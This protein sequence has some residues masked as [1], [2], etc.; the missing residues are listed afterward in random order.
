MKIAFKFFLVFIVVSCGKVYKEKKEVNN[1]ENKLGFEMT[2]HL[3]ELL[4]E[5]E[6][7]LDN[8]YNHNKYSNKYISYLEDVID[9]NCS[10]VWNLDSLSSYNHKLKSNLLGYYELPDSVMYQGKSFI[11]YNNGEISSYISIID[12]DDNQISI[13]SLIK[14]LSNE[15]VWLG[16]GKFFLALD[17]TEHSHI[18]NYY[19]EET[20]KHV[21]GFGIY[22]LAVMLLTNTID[23][24][25]YF[26]KRI[27]LIESIL[28]ENG[29]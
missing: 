17:S 14:K 5:F 26:I 1:F 11:T 10:K 27:I 3:N 28:H 21:H 22:D 15:L 24:D 25:D 9:S 29:C 12:S 19:L 6:N 2:V 18:I 8:S 13:D 23:F 20:H 7:Y 16:R 4:K